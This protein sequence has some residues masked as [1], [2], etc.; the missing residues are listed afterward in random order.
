MRSRTEPGYDRGVMISERRYELLRGV[1]KARRASPFSSPERRA[2][3]RHAE[4]ALF[5]NAEIL[6]EGS[7][8][9]DIDADEPR[10]F[11]SVMISIPFDALELSLRGLDESE[12]RAQFVDCCEGS[13]RIRLRAMR[14]ACA[15]VQRRL[16]GR[17]IGTAN[18]ETKIAASAGE[19]H[20]DVDVE[21]P[22]GLSF[23]ATRHR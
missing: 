13:M 22:F 14:L 3:S 15:E 17:E 2:I 6:V 23:S 18:V 7:F 4:E 10:F 8:D 5:E 12:V 11:G 20:I 1:A 16:P 9:A 21:V 19:L